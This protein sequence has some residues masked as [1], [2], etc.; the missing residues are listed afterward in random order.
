MSGSPQGVWR[1]GSS[2]SKYY[3]NKSARREL[4]CAFQVYLLVGQELKFRRMHHDEAS[5]IFGSCDDHRI[6]FAN[7][8]H[9]ADCPLNILTDDQTVVLEEDLYVGGAA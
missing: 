3:A 5:D 2:N 1:P 9:A 4:T 7:P 8:A 6:R